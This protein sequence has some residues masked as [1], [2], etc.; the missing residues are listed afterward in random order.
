MM[1]KIIVISLQNGK[2]LDTPK[3]ILMLWQRTAS[4]SSQIV[5][6]MLCCQE[7][8]PKKKHNLVLV[9]ILPQ[10]CCVS[11]HKPQCWWG[12]L[13]SSIIVRILQ[14]N[15]RVYQQFIPSIGHSWIIQHVLQSL[16]LHGI[17]S[18]LSNF[19]GFILCLA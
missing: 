13:L 17:R 9:S 12:A 19:H 1:V 11:F 8:R 4:F 2:Y 15:A 16:K 10:S 5:F 18:C 3:I 6:S 7:H 14:H